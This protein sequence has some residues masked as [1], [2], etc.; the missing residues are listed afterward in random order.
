MKI[1]YTIDA[2]AS[3]TA[4]INFIEAKNTAGAGIRWLNHYEIF[5]EKAFINAKQKKLC[6]NDTF[7]N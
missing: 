2:F 7:K 1:E 3:L 6:H 4:L 5:L